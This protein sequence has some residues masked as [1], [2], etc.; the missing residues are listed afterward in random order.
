MTERQERLFFC[1]VF[2]VGIM[3]QGGAV[4]KLLLPVE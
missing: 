3:L 1:A 2:A 4:L